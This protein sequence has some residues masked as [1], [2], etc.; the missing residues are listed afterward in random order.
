MA[1]QAI[2]DQL[3]PLL[4]K[5]DQEASDKVK[6]LYTLLEEA[7][8]IDASFIKEA[9]R[10]GRDPDHRQHHRS[11]SP[12]RDMASSSSSSG[13]RHGQGHNE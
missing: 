7:T 5:Y 3:T 6:H 12:R 13:E 9:K 2:V 8:L 10:R 11:R 1:S 4:P